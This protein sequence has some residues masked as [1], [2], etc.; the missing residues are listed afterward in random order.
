MNLQETTKGVW[1]NQDAGKSLEYDAILT[2]CKS[3]GEYCEDGMYADSDGPDDF[4][5]VKCK[6]ECHI[7]ELE[8][9]N[10]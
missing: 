8:L 6:C 4:Q 5:M 1:T 2:D 9:D 10:E 7:T 3:C